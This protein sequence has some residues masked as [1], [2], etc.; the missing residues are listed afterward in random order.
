M[1]ALAGM[2]NALAGVVV[3]DRDVII[4]PWTDISSVVLHFQGARKVSRGLAGMLE[5]TNADGGISRYRPVAYQTV[6]GKRKYLVPEFRIVDKDRATVRVNQ[7]DPSLPL[8]IGPVSGSHMK[9]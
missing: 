2:G 8:V 6:N 9:S 1:M 7:A 3:A 5:V 4:E